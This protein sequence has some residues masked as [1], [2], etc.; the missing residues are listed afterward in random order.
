MGIS[1]HPLG[2]SCY[3]EFPF[4]SWSDSRNYLYE[5]ERGVKPAKGTNS[6]SKERT[7]QSVLL[8]AKGY[9]KNVLAMW[10][11]IKKKAS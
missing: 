4:I 11:V 7:N 5:S 3:D 6:L 10:P 9:S 1:K 2:G 8:Y